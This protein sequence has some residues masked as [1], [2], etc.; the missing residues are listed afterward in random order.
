MEQ[1]ASTGENHL[2]CGEIKDDF[3]AFWKL[4]Q[5]CANSS[6][7]LKD[8]NGKLLSD[9]TSTAARWQE[10]FSTLLNQP[11]QPTPDALVSEAIASIPDLFPSPK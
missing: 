6:D 7:P 5:K 8:L 9:R 1:V 2:Q 4:R 3:A 10:H 11:I